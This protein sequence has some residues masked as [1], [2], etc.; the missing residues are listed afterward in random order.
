MRWV[1]QMRAEPCPS[2]RAERE[3]EIKC[4]ASCACGESARRARRIALLLHLLRLCSTPSPVAVLPFKTPYVGIMP[5]TY[6]GLGREGG[7]GRKSVF[8]NGY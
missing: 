3:P 5:H 1:L 4:R 7:L 2:E 8:F 6:R